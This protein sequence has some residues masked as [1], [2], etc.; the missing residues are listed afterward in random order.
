[1]TPQ[2]LR[3]TA[4]LILWTLIGIACSET[5]VTMEVEI[6]GDR[7]DEEKVAWAKQLAEAEQEAI[8]ADVLAAAPNASVQVVQKLNVTWGTKNSVV[9]IGDGPSES[10][11]YLIVSVN[12]PHSEGSR[13][14]FEVAREALMRRISEWAQAPSEVPDIAPSGGDAKTW[15]R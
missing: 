15:S 2:A 7:S 8:R 14:V 6:T 13:V 1:V 10:L 9:L 3:S 4:T 12:A 11:V 5:T